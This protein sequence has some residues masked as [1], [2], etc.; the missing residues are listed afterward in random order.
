VVAD[1]GLLAGELL[2]RPTDSSMAVSLV[3]AEAAEGYVEAWR[4][5]SDGGV[6]AVSAHVQVDGGEVAVLQLS[7][8]QPASRYEFR[9]QWRRAGEVG[10]SPRPAGT[11]QTA[12][13]AGE[14]FT[15]T[16][17]ADS[18]LDEK[19]NLDLYRQTLAN[20]VAD[21]PDFHVDLGDTFMAE[22]HS[23]PFDKTVAPAPDEATVRARYLFERQHFGLLGRAVPL[24]LV[25]GNH[26]GEAGYLGTAA[27]GLP[28]WASRARRGYFPN[29]VA[30]AFVS[31]PPLDVPLVGNRES[32]WAFTWGNALFVGLDPYW[33]TANK[34]TGGENWGW[35]LGQAQYQWLES[36]LTASTATYKFLF[37][38]H[39][40]GGAG[41]ANRGGVEAAG[42][43]EWGGAHADGGYGFTDKR[44]GWARPIHQLA[45][46]TGVTAVFHGHDHLY[47]HQ[48]KDGITYLEVPQPS[49][50]NGTNFATLAT[51]GGYVSG[52]ALGSSG[53]VRCS[54]SPAQ[55]TCSYVR[56]WVPGL[57][58]TVANGSVAHS[59]TVTP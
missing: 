54:V 14:P 10:F 5:P 29:P 3:A 59:W 12:R 42:L 39:L 19:S 17:Q 46:D 49:A 47:V 26:E 56:S 51:E 44:P 27:D 28:L 25:N 11:F 30:G 41:N 6:D 15:F 9:V 53:H 23:A 13:P 7:G 2:S 48:V 58:E 34:K 8:L 18:H 40:V 32:A 57:K 35:T 52:T 24:L 4:L 20:V 37:L 31:A 38:H 50:S 45:V 33:F 36:T 21:G 55:V 16:V 22:K 1:G 43:Y